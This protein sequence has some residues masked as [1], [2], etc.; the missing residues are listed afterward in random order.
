MNCNKN[1]NS[2]LILTTIISCNITPK[3]K[4]SNND[5]VQ[6][7]SCV[8]GEKPRLYA[9]GDLPCVKSELII[10]DAEK[11]KIHF[12]V[13]NSNSGDL[14]EK[15]YQELLYYKNNKIIEKIKLRLDDDPYWSEVYFIRIRK[16]KYFS[17]ID[18]D[19]HLEFAILPFSPGSSAWATARIYSLKKKITFW[20]QGRYQ[21][22][23]D[24]F[25][26]LNCMDCSNFNPDA[27][28]KCD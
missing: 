5:N 10:S 18:G 11:L 13:N 16:Q 1:L 3:V 8:Q 27:C 19:G 24:T 20:G 26:K 9:R 17:D 28:L 7:A 25:V 23:G 15:G 22:E 21:F 2:L 4:N 14:Y 6:I 12:K